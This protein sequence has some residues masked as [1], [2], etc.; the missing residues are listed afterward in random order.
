MPAWLTLK[1]GAYV[2]G[3]LLSLGVMWK[4][5]DVF[6]AEPR[7]LQA[8]LDRTKAELQA[9]EKVEQINNQWND[10]LK[11]ISAAHQETMRQR[12]LRAES[13]KEVL[14]DRE[15]LQ[16]GSAGKPGLVAK[17]ANRKTQEVFDELES[18]YND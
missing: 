10:A 8:D 17:L 15:K 6:I 7:R 4:V 5:Y 11:V 12:D 9:L 13:E 16:R 3:A 2:V 18:I 14:L 1:L